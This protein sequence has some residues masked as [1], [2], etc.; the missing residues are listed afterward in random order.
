MR[1]QLRGDQPDTGDYVRINGVWWKLLNRN[2][3]NDFFAV[4]ADGEYKFLGLYADQ[5]YLCWTRRACADCT[6]LDCHSYTCPKENNVREE[7][8][9]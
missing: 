5:G 6:Y 1:I 8:R 4:N 7:A 9:C 2:V 3:R